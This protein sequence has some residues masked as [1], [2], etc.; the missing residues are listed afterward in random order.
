M[1]RRRE[2]RGLSIERL[3]SRIVRDLKARADPSSGEFLRSYLGSPLP[4][5]G[6]RTPKV[7]EVV[8]GVRPN[9]ESLPGKSAQWLL[10]ALWDGDSYEER[11][12]AIELAR[13]YGRRDDPAVWTLARR[14]LESATGWA[15]SDSLASEVVGHCVRVRPERFAELLRWARS[16]SLWRRRAATYA[17]HDWVRSGDLRQ[18]FRLLERLAPDPELWVQRAVGTWLRECWKRDR[19]RT[20]RFLRRHA[21]ELSPI[22]LTVATERAPRAFRSELRERHHRDFRPSPR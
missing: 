17:L 20:E 7:R 1:K 10:S 4:V 3:R 21:R 12:V 16:S 14:W 5:L 18:P 2:A 11:L 6:V 9:F 15:L 22:A 13:I 19:P 8:R